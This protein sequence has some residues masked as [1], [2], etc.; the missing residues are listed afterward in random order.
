M[1]VG[2]LSDGQR[3]EISTS[4]GCNYRIPWT[5]EEVSEAT[6]CSFPGH[7]VY[8]AV[9]AL[10]NLLKNFEVDF[11]YGRKYVNILHLN[12]NYVHK[13]RGREVI[14]KLQYTYRSL[15]NFKRDFE[16]AGQVMY[17]SDTVAEW[18]LVY[19]VPQLDELYDFLVKTKQILQESDWRPR[20]LPVVLKNYPDTI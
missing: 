10:P 9:I 19:L 18:L 16:K 20:P 1:Q 17:T 8:E 5:P 2:E 6:R 4:L 15:V 12:Y 14:Q 7:E 13:A 11:E 3:Q